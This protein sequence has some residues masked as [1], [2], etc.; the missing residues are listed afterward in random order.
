MLSLYVAVIIVLDTSVFVS[1]IMSVDGAARE[2]LRR[3][4]LGEHEALMGQALFSEYESVVKRDELFA[5]APISRTERIELWQAFLHVCRWVQVYF[6]WRPNLPD[7][8]DNHV[9]ELALA[10]GASHIVTHNV[11]DFVRS[12]LQ[13]A[14]LTVVT[15]KQFLK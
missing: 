2:V 7:E 15:P 14:Q 13:F 6:L 1:A 4:L 8:A 5:Q 10:G 9:V 11:R 3:C 12:E